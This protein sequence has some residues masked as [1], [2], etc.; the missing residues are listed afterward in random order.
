MIN[1]IIAFLLRV[2]PDIS[3]FLVTITDYQN[4]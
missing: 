1:D 2:I 3:G 4:S